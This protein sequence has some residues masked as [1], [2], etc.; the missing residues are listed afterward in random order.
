MRLE[1]ISSGE[2]PPCE[3]WPCETCPDHVA[4][5]VVIR[6][7]QFICAH[8]AAEKVGTPW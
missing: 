5:F 6:N 8:C 1:I 4:D 3:D 2:G 7:G